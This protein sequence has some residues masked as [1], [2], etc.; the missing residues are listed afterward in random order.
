MKPDEVREALRRRYAS[1][2]RQSVGQFN[3]PVGRQ[4]AGLLK[5]RA[6][7]LELIPADVV[8]HFVGVGNPFSLG[9]PRAGWRVVDVGCGG[10]FDSQVAAH[11]VGHRGQVIGLDMSGEMLAVARD[12]LVASDLYNVSFVEGYAEDLPVEA[13]WADLVISNGVL[14]LSTCKTSAFAEIARVLRSGGWFQAVDLILVKE[15]PQNLQNDEFAW[16]N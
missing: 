12:G 2:A 6:D 4:S 15:L 7:F 3:Y 11:Y 8:D 10:G 9:E 14:N 16:S 5:Y 13:G 1:V